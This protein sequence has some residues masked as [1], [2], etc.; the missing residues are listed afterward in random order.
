MRFLLRIQRRIGSVA[1]IGGIIFMIL[2]G[3]LFDKVCWIRYQKKQKK[4]EMMQKKKKI[5]E[6]ILSLKDE[7]KV[8]ENYYSYKNDNDFVLFLDGLFKKNGAK[9]IQIDIVNTKNNFS[10]V[11][12]IRIFMI[13]SQM[14]YKSVIELLTYFQKNKAVSSIEEF[15]I[16][17]PKL[18]NQDI[19]SLE[20]VYT[21]LLDVSI[22]ILF[23]A[24]F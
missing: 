17:L 20:Q 12:H 7:N 2:I 23:P 22:K 6:R 13:T 5:F 19:M 3:S 21:P 8:K 14:T 1:I 18:E 4:F 15:N 24:K 16:V 9:N 11:F 10:Q